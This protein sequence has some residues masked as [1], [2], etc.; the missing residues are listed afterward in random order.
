MKYVLFAIAALIFVNVVSS[1]ADYQMKRDV[2][3]LNYTM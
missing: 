1:N 3:H 2:Q